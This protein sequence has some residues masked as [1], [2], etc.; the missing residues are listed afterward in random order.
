MVSYMLTRS[1]KILDCIQ[2][3]Q[4][5]GAEIGALDRPIVTRQM[6]QIRYI[7]HDTTEA[8]KAKYA[9][10]GHQVDLCSIVDVDY[11]WGEKG[12]ADLLAAEA[13]LDYVIASHVIEHVPSLIGWLSEVR[14]ILKPGGILSLAIPDKRQCFDCQRS[15][16]KTA[17]VVE[18][19]LLNSKAPSA[20][21]IFDYLHSAVSFQGNIAW[22]GAVNEA[23]FVHCHSILDAWNV[24]KQ[25]V[26]TSDY[27]DV[28]CWVFTPCSFFKILQDLITLNLLK[29]EVAQFYDTE[30]CEFLVSLRAMDDAPDRAHLDPLIAGLAGTAPLVTEVEDTLQ[31]LHVAQ[32][33]VV[34][35]ESSKFWKMRTAWLKIKRKLRVLNP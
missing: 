20:R 2:P 8:L 27:C 9:P 14:A 12:L 17:D 33:R 21:Q 34:A 15:L 35:M 18:A 10:S 3:S 29:F 11:V 28:H 32:Q 25:A 22:G 13:P 7:D 31:K 5:I 26:T 30:G 4:Q 16:T 19:Y 1:E 24:K 6:G 23:D